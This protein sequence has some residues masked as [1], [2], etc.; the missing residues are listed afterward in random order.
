MSARDDKKQRKL[1]KRA[2]AG[3]VAVPSLPDLR[4]KA[5]VIL[6]MHRSGTSALTGALAEMGCVM[7]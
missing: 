4:R 2:L 6:G 3:P 5:I 1:E 7:P